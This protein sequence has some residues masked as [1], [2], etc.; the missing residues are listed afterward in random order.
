MKC[1]NCKKRGL[2]NI[3]AIRAHLRFCPNRPDR[4]QDDEEIRDTRRAGGATHS[5]PS[6]R[7]A[8]EVPAYEDIPSVD[9]PGVAELER[10]GIEIIGIDP[11]SARIC[12]N[13]LGGVTR[14]D[15]PLSMWTAML[16]CPELSPGE[17]RRWLRYWCAIREMPLNPWQ[18]A[19][20]GWDQMWT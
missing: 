7:R 9:I 16:W 18:E 20:M 5:S 6:T 12:A 10:A 13:Y 11:R 19:A 3:Q 14:L 4:P 17:R 8:P 1:F 2:A 15:D